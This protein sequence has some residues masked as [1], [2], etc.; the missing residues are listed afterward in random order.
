MAQKTVRLKIVSPKAHLLAEQ[1]PTLL[2]PIRQHCTTASP[3]PTPRGVCSPLTSSNKQSPRGEWTCQ[4]FISRP[5]LV[6]TSTARTPRE[7][8]LLSSRSDGPYCGYV[9]ITHTVTPA[10]CVY[11]FT[12]RGRRLRGLQTSSPSLLAI[13]SPQHH[14]CSPLQHLGIL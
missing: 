12:G 1:Q 11:K 5:C 6:M 9:Y 14:C 4:I 7:P 3:S 8:E 2:P 13:F 10:F